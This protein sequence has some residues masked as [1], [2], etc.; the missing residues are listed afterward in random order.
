METQ[1]KN[2]QLKNLPSY[3]FHRVVHYFHDLDSFPRLKAHPSYVENT[4]HLFNLTYPQ[5][6]KLIKG[7]PIG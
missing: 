7:S 1:R 3:P 6:E 4:H 2:M 5:E